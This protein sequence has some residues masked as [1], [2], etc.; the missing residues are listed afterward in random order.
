MNKPHIWKPDNDAHNDAFRE[1]LELWGDLDLAT[2]SYSSD[3]FC[4]A[5]GEKEFLLY[6]W[7]RVDD[8]SIPSFV[9][10]LFCNTV[11]DIPSSSL[12][13]SHGILKTSF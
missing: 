5:D 1:M 3:D 7:P 8:R 4:W 6:D 13:S 2:F 12:D 9:V 11:Q 10:S